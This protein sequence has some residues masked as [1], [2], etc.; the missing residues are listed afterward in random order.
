M[1][2]SATG[3]KSCAQNGRSVS[4][5]VM[6]APGHEA[7]PHSSVRK[8]GVAKWR[9]VVLVTVHVLI[10]IH[11]VQWLVQGLTVSPVEPS[12][13]MYTLEVGKVNAGFVFFAA[14]IASTLLFGRFFCG[15]GCHMVAF[16]DLCAHWMTKLGV[17]P[18]VFRSRLLLWVPLL[19]ALYMFV[20]PAIRREVLWPLSRWW[21][22]EMLAYVYTELAPSTLMVEWARKLEFGLPWWMGEAFKFP[23]FSNHFIVEDFWATF[24]PWWMTIPFMLTCTFAMVYFLGS[25]GLCNYACPYGGFFGVA[26]RLSV[27]RIEVNDNCNQCG[28]CT[29]VCTSNVRVHQEVRDYGRVVDPGCLRCM[30]CTSVCPT[31]ALSFKFGT[32]AVFAKA[33][34]PE[35][36]SGRVRRPEFDL[37]VW[38]EVAV[39]AVGLVVFYSWRSAWNQ[40]PMLMAASIGAIGG[41]AAWKCWSL[42]TVPNVRLQSLQL[43]A[44]GRLRGAGVAFVLLSLVFFAVTAW[45]GWVRVHR[46]IAE[47]L[48]VGVTAAQ[49]VVFTPTY[50]PDEDQKRDALRAV[51][52]LER[53]GPRSVGGYGW[54]LTP[55]Q[56][57]RVAW[58]KAV[59]GDLPGA[60]NAL[61]RGMSQGMPSEELVISAHRIF[62]LQRK[63][64]ADFSAAM[65]RVLAE[66]PK[67]AHVRV[68][69]GYSKLQ[70]NEPEAG[71]ARFKE[72]LAA[73]AKSDPRA[74]YRAVDALLQIGRAEE[75]ISGLD[76]QIADR[77]WVWELLELRAGIATMQGES[78]AA[79]D[80]LQRA[81]KR[82][83]KNAGL[84]AKLSDA[85][86]ACG[87]A[88]GAKLA[89]ERAESLAR[90]Q[91]VPTE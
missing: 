5:R 22:R 9:A 23:G 80:L 81:V 76:Q 72:V 90:D 45:A 58:L 33:R 29:A 32:P 74:V 3:T 54:N 13:S 34:T 19:M 79:A 89:R 57:N 53:S 20:W 48:D 11:I 21:G 88:A 62:A 87:D 59:A 69:V 43:R 30:D 1:T 68:A 75:A 10:A 44:K 6:P 36:K 84:W 16:Q 31:H 60:E 17:R 24:P 28:H 14:A 38:Q 41:F 49:E 73:G 83:P 86:T 15:W 70:Q 46:R 61:E 66:N 63:T 8:S 64:N 39:L 71:I 4:L 91:K 40:I 56:W 82:A 18:R 25:K 55:D 52:H 50:V 27:G 78:R 47:G 37:S 42:A 35:A 85:R 77:P 51:A 67:A 12:E 2:S 7:F 26:D 65:E